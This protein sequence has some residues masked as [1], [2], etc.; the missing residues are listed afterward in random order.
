MLVTGV[1]N[2]RVVEQCR[3]FFQAAPPGAKTIWS[4]ITVSLNVRWRKS[5]LRTEPLQ[6]RVIWKITPKNNITGRLSVGIPSNKSIKFSTISMSWYAVAQWKCDS[7]ATRSPAKARN[8]LKGSQMKSRG[9]E[10]T[11]AWIRFQHA[12]NHPSRTICTRHASRA[13]CKGPIPL[14]PQIPTIT[15]YQPRIA[16]TTAKSKDSQSIHRTESNPTCL[17]E[18]QSVVWWDGRVW[19]RL[20]VAVV[21]PSC[22]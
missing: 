15:K 17:N 1:P 20:S 3:I 13:N 4:N 16:Q 8:N 5:F 10:P 9:R 19:S 6:S 7:K 2:L 14:H 11:N 22:S 21:L 12:G 18:V